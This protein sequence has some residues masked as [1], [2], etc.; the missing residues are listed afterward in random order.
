MD[1]FYGPGRQPEIV[2]A[3]RQL[4]I[5]EMTTAWEPRQQRADVSSPAQGR[6][7]AVASTACRMSW[8]AA[9]GCDTNET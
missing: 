3:P 4:S 6:A 1:P 9:S 8:V 5:I 2:A 7:A